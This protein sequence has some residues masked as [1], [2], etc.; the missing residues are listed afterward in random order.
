MG[1]CPIDRGVECRTIHLLLKMRV[2]DPGNGRHAL[3][4][5]LRHAE[6]RRSVVADCPHIDLRRKAEIEDL[7]HHVGRLEIE[8]VLRKRRRQH[9]TQPANVVGGRCMALFERHQDDSVIDANGRAIREGE[10]VRPRR[11]PD[12]VDNQ[13]AVFLGDDFANL[14]FDRLEN[15]LGQFN[16]GSGG[17]AHVQLNL[18]AV[19]GRKEI[20]ADQQHHGGR[21]DRV[22][23]RPRSER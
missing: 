15:P 8:H 14:V 10:I 2:D 19:D 17:C 18:P 20:A 7:R 9:L 21:R 13:L 6:V 16:S 12:I 3:L 4:Q 23:G 11:Q 1:P 22:S 5:F